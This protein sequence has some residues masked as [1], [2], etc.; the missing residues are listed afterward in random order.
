MIEGNY[1][2]IFE[3]NSYRKLLKMG[4]SDLRIISSY[5]ASLCSL[6]IVT[7]IS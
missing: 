1:T 5:I 4:H 3:Q 2:I 7:H 6:E